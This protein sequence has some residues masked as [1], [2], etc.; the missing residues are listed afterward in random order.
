MQALL[1][2]SHLPTLQTCCYLQDLGWHRRSI[3]IAKRQDARPPPAAAIPGAITAQAATTSPDY[4]AGA[5]WTSSHSSGAEKQPVILPARTEFASLADAASSSRAAG[6]SL[7]HTVADAKE[8]LA[9]AT[10][11]L[12]RTSAAQMIAGLQRQ[13]Q[14]LRAVQSHMRTAGDAVQHG[15]LRKALK[16]HRSAHWLSRRPLPW[17]WNATPGVSAAVQLGAAVRTPLQ[18]EAIWNMLRQARQST[19]VSAASED[20]SLR[21]DT[22]SQGRGFSELWGRLCE[23][24]MPVLRPSRV[25]PVMRIRLE[26]T[27][28]K[29]RRAVLDHTSAV[30]EVETCCRGSGAA[31]VGPSLLT[32]RKPAGMFHAVSLSAKQQVLG[33]VRAFADMRWEVLPEYAADGAGAAAPAAAAASPA[34][35]RS[36]RQRCQGLQAEQVGCNIGVD[37]CLGFARASAWYSVTKRQGM[38]ELRV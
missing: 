18:P 10:S 3:S 16:V 15:R 23:P 19:A 34:W 37:V 22:A 32:T 13:M 6:Y 5:L 20:T 28:G 30:L 36:V 26:G 21:T 8:A 11:A 9:D 27:L 14:D 2:I 1:S 4:N 35:I 38:V 12:Q 25:Q 7:Q 33:P 24:V 17:L 31:S 29:F